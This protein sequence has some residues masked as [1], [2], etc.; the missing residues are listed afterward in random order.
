MCNGVPSRIIGPPDPLGSH[1]REN[2]EH[3]QSGMF[4]SQTVGPYTAKYAEVVLSGT[5]S[6]VGVAVR[7]E[8]PPTFRSTLP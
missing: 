4:G 2:K 8:P 6:C 1:S 7:P 3:D 5:I